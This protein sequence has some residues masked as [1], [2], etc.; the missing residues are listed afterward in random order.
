MMGMA[1]GI[2]A[3]TVWNGVIYLVR[4]KQVGTAM[5]LGASACN[6]GLFAMPLLMGQLKDNFPQHDQGYFWVTRLSTLMASI[7]WAVSI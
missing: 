5:G 2:M 6:L 4:G 1:Y 3:G 7:S